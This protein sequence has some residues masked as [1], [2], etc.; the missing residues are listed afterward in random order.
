MNQYEKPDMEIIYMEENDVIK[1]SDKQ[2][3]DG[4]NENKDDNGSASD[5]WGW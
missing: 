4:G 3:I 1:T 2:L 5:L